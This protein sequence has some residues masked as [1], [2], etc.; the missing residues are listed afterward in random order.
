MK[1]NI[2]KILNLCKLK[3]LD[4]NE[5]IKVLK[6]MVLPPLVDDKSELRDNLQNLMDMDRKFAEK[7]DKFSRLFLGEKWLYWNVWKRIRD[8]GIGHVSSFYMIGS[9]F[10]IEVRIRLGVHRSNTETKEEF[11]KREKEFFENSPYLYKRNRYV[12]NIDIVDDVTNKRLLLDCFHK[13]LKFDKYEIQYRDDVFHKVCIYA[14]S[15]VPYEYEE[16]NIG[17]SLAV[18]ENIEKE[19]MEANDALRYADYSVNLKDTVDSLLWSTYTH[20]C[21]LLGY[22]NEYNNEYNKVILSSKLRNYDTKKMAEDIGKSVSQ[23]EMKETYKFVRDMFSKYVAKKYM[24]AVHTKWDQGLL[25]NG[26]FCE[27]DSLLVLEDDEE[28][29]GVFDNIADIGNWSYIISGEHAKLVR[30]NLMC[31][32]IEDINMELSSSDFHINSVAGSIRDMEALD[33]IAKSIV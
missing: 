12:N 21:G 29:I 1:T 17:F 30:D 13:F 25:F 14:K 33:K 16:K 23:E 2:D 7:N 5:Y 18:V 19:F 15:I 3:C 26:T 24:L 28:V 32:G 11:K 8:L 6:D 31:D 22:S 27:K 9:Y 20:T 4:K 10:F